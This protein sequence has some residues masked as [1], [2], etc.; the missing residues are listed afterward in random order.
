MW[1]YTGQATSMQNYMSAITHGGVSFTTANNIVIGPITVPCTGT[2]TS[3]A[4][5]NSLACDGNAP[6]GWQQAADKIAQQV[7]GWDR[8]EH[9]CNCHPCKLL[10]ACVS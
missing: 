8:S 2:L 10:A 1:G 3:G 9:W 6:W 7:G 4:T 5:Y